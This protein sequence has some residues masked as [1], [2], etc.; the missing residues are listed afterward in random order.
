MDL[1]NKILLVAEAQS[2]RF[3]KGDEPFQITSRLL[4]ECGEVAWELNHYPRKNISIERNSKDNK[5]NLVTETYQAMT[6][7][8]QLLQYFDLTDDFV[9]KIEVVYKEFQDKGYINK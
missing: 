4:E 2:R 5:G 6:V 7:L 3:P 9:N 8:G 1:L